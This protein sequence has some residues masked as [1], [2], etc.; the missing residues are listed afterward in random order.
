MLRLFLHAEDPVVPVQLGDAVE[1]R[2]GR[3]GELV[4]GERAPVA[5]RTPEVDV[6]REW[7]LEQV[8]GRD[9]EQVVVREPPVAERKA[10]IA[11]SAEAVVVRARPVVVDDDVLVP[12]PLLEGGRVDGVRDDVHRVDLARPGDAVEDPVRHR[13][14]ADRQQGLRDGLRQRPEPGRIARGEEENLHDATTAA[15][16][17]PAYGGSCTPCSVT[18]AVT[19]VP[20]VTSKAGLRAVKRAVTSPGSRSSIGISAPLSIE[21]STVELGATT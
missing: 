3:V 14:A 2:Q 1:R 21:W 16:S 18:I 15:S 10:N 12:G 7:E 11:E 4:H 6:A 20:G 13:P 9:H 8:V 5:L 17:E 19:S